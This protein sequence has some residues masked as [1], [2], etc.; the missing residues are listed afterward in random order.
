MRESNTHATKKDRIQCLEVLISRR[1]ITNS[2]NNL[3]WTLSVYSLENKPVIKNRAVHN[4]EVFH[5]MVYDWNR[6][7]KQLLDEYQIPYSIIEFFSPENFY[8]DSID[9]APATVGE[10]KYLS[11]LHGIQESGATSSR[12]DDHLVSICDQEQLDH[13]QG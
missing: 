2:N 4:S 7:I 8:T 12:S 13:V 9:A 11:S 1:Y 10:V 3:L 6:T 5:F